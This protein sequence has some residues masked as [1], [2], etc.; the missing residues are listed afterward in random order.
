MEAEMSALQ[1]ATEAEIVQELASRF[2]TLVIAGVYWN[3][4]EM[5][6]FAKGTEPEILGCCSIMSQQVMAEAMNISD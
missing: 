1:R 6:R 2:R 3:D 4:N 5:I